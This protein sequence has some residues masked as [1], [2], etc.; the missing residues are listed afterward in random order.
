LATPN[1]DVR[2]AIVQCLLTIKVSELDS[3]EVAKLVTLLGSYKNLG[4]GKT[5]QVISNIMMILTKIVVGGD[6][7]AK[8]DFVTIYSENA[9]LDALDILIRN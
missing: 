7:A 9:T 2:L 8:L 3:K 5:E 4:A 1:D 6:S